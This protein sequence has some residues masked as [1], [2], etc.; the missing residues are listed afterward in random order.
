MRALVVYESMFGNTRDVAAAIA[1]GL[2]AH[3]DVELVEVGAAPAELPEDVALIVV[4]GPTH[5][6]GMS[7]A[8]S[9][10]DSAKRFEPGLVSP[11]IGI[12]EWLETVADAA[13]VPRIALFDTRIKG[14][15]LLWGSAAQSA[16]KQLWRARIRTFVP[17]ESFHVGGPTGPVVDRLIDGELERARAWGGRLGAA[18]VGA[19][20]DGA[21]T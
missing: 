18:A 17:P 9:R 7:T 4:G 21:R 2:G 1:D 3:A 6:H 14:P 19:A 15:G 11:G 20:K 10:A 8:K 5:A 13:F 16:A 12:R